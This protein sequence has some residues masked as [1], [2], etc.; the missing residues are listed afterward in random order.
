M[1]CNPT[2]VKPKQQNFKK[3]KAFSAKKKVQKAELQ[4]TFKTTV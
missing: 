1:F 2:K 3:C 4:V